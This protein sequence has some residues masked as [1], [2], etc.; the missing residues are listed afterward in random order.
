MNTTLTKS[1]N[2]R[3]L[4]YDYYSISLVLLRAILKKY[5]PSTLSNVKHNKGNIFCTKKDGCTHLYR[6]FC[7]FTKVW[8]Q[9]KSYNIYPTKDCTL[10]KQLS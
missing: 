1:H 6:D 2:H 4:I 10:F 3:L 9:I 7:I 5:I 8:K